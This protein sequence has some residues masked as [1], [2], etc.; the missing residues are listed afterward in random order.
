MTMSRETCVVALGPRPSSV[1]EEPEL[2]RFRTQP[3][4][5]ST[6]VLEAGES[7]CHGLHERGRPGKE[8]GER[9]TRKRSGC[10]MIYEIGALHLAA[11]GKAERARERDGE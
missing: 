2:E 6:A 7:A 1:V 10:W 11:S 4:W 9:R 8:E 5:S 3:V